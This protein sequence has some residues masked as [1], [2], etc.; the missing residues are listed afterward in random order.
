MFVRGL[1]KRVRALS[2]TVRTRIAVNKYKG[3]VRDS[4]EARQQLVIVVVGSGRRYRHIA[5]AL[6]WSRCG[7]RR[8][9]AAHCLGAGFGVGVAG[10]GV[11]LTV[12][13]SKFTL[14]PARTV[15]VPGVVPGVSSPLD[16]IVH[17]RLGG[18]TLNLGVAVFPSASTSIVEVVAVGA[19]PPGGAATTTGMDAGVA[20]HRRNTV[21]PT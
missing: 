15:T 2:A 18:R 5:T 7:V 11:R 13:S 4:S 20:L 10:R 3:Q 16:E 6:P 19:V 17:P 9:G 21:G 14:L 12:V 1:S 8:A